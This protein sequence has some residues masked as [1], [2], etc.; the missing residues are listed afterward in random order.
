MKLKSL[1]MTGIENVVT[2]QKNYM[3]IFTAICQT[4]RSVID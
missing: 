4:L 2:D 1:D 3:I